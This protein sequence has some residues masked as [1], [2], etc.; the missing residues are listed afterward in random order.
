MTKVCYSH[1]LHYLILLPLPVFLHVLYAHPYFI[2]DNMF[3]WRVQDATPLAGFY[4]RTYSPSSWPLIDW[5]KDSKIAVRAAKNEIQIFD[6]AFARQEGGA[7]ATPMETIEVKNLE[8]VF[9]SPAP[10]PTYSFVSFAPTIG[11][12]MACYMMWTYSYGGKYV[13]TTSKNINADSA[14]VRFAED[15]S[16]ALVEMITKVAENSYYGDSKLF[17]ISKD[18]RVN[19]GINPTK[20]GR[21]HDFA[22]GRSSEGNNFFVIVGGAAPPVA[23]LHN[24]QGGVLHQ[25]EPG[26]YNSI[27]ISPNGRI[28]LLSGFGG[29]NG[30]MAFW[31]IATRKRLGPVVYAACVVHSEWSPDSKYLLTTTTRPR[32]Q[33]DNGI[34]VFNYRGQVVLRQPMNVLYDAF[35]VPVPKTA[36]P[37]RAPSPYKG[38]TAAGGVQEGGVVRSSGAY[39]P[40]SARAGA[41][42]VGIPGAVFAAP[43]LGRRGKKKN[44]NAQAGEGAE[45]TEKPE[46]TEKA[47][48]E[49]KRKGASAT[50]E[51]T[52]KSE[53]TLAA[54]SVTLVTSSAEIAKTKEIRKLQRKI[55][56]IEALKE[57]KAKGKNLDPLQEEKIKSEA[58]IKSQLASLGT[59]S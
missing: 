54:S 45:A 35:F 15:G 6:G 51:T 16:A 55:R 7:Q 21:L 34:S 49:N 46:K 19:Q 53:P 36:F 30:A 8:C 32:L 47:P 14:H 27:R 10:A 12:A 18:G 28:L 20:E 25:F 42:P 11:N 52:K 4:H 59:V 17:L 5:S 43:H 58:E 57:E 22:W 39:V 1:S 41:S 50:A 40:P 38:D 2:A 13:C 44:K 31:D 29:M 26:S 33:V 3:V 56:E 37:D 23:S 24:A 9:V 48:Q